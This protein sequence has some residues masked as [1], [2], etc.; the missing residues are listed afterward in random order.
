MGKKRTHVPNKLKLYREQAGYTQR[1]IAG[2]L[3]F[4]TSNIVSSWENDLS[5]PSLEYVLK[6]QH[7]YHTLPGELFAEL[8]ERYREDVEVALKR[9]FDNQSEKP[10]FEDDS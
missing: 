9:Y 5:R 6:L 2:I 7:L 8:N 10:E 1:D 3:E 4:K